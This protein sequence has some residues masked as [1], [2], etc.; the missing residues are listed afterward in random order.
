MF[1]KRLLAKGRLKQGELNP[2]ESKYQRHLE[3]R[4]QAGEVLWYKFEAITFKLAE[5]TTYRPDFM[6]MLADGSLETHEV[7]GA[8]AIFMDDAKV[9]VK[10]FAE[11][12]PIR[13]LVVYPTKNNQWIIEEY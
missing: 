7:K 3:L 9:K 2:C 10:V 11:Q 4:K 5:R 12:F 13:M 8:K 6:V 1:S